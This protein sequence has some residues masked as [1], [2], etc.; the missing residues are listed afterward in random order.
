[1]KVFETWHLCKIMACR[2]SRPRFSIYGVEFGLKIFPDKAARL[3][4]LLWCSPAMIRFGFG[5]CRPAWRAF[6][7]I[8][9]G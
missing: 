4:G 3:A 1:M 7:D 9:I 6:F 5:I 8:A 2:A